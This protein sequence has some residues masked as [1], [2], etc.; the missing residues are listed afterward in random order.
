ML[1]KENLVSNTG[2]IKD[3]SRDF[4]QELPQFQDQQPNQ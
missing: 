1:K 4:N 3:K 2:W